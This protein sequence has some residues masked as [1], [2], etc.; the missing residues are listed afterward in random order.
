MTFLFFSSIV[1]MIGIVFMASL[2]NSQTKIPQVSIILPTFN[3]EKTIKT[4]M[5][6]VLRQSFFNWE[7]IIIDDGSTDNTRE[8]IERYSVKDSRIILISHEKNKGLQESLNHGL[9]LARGTYIARIDDDDVWINTNKLQKQVDFLN[10]NKE[11]VLVGTGAIVVDEK[12]SEITR[13]LMPET[14]TQIRKKILRANT[15]IH[16]S[17]I[18]RTES[19]VS[20][21][22]YQIEKMLEDYDLWLRLGKI[23]KFKNL[24]EYSICYS[25]N[26]EGYNFHNK[27]VRLKSNLLL[28][29]EYS[30][31]YPHYWKAVILNWIK[32]LSYP[33]F[34]LMPTTLKGVLL[35]LHKKIWLGK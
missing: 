33:L 9:S 22:G 25:F 17:V 26:T 10:N 4:A 11:Y 5:H 2:S 19:V 12:G 16:S 14:D 29:K 18:Y 31:F 28:V 13:Y 30:N 23:G 24:Q 6:S 7:L 35:G 15:F 20:V 27:I 8:C 21:G 34:I 3:G 1:A 32:V